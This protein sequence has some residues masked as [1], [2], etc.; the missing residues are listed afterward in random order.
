VLELSL[1]TS[2]SGRGMNCISSEKPTRARLGGFAG[3]LFS[4]LLC[5]MS[6]F[7]NISIPGN[8]VRLC[9]SPLGLQ[10]AEPPL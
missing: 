1:D 2:E 6:L 7:D 4:E 8:G 3:G 9:S 5:A 10:G